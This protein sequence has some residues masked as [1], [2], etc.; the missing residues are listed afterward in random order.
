MSTDPGFPLDDATLVM[1]RSSC[2]INPDNG[3]TNLLA[4]LHMGSRVE[5]ATDISD[6]VDA[7]APVYFV[8]YEEGAEPFTVH[9]VIVALI[10][11]VFRLRAEVLQT[12]RGA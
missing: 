11:E 12:E 1:L 9:A 4:F 8:E 5:H 6:E 7:A 2:E 10:D 3:Q